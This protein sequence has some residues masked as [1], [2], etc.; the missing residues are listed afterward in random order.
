VDGAVFDL[1]EDVAKELLSKPTRPGDVLD[2]PHKLP[3]LQMDELR[4]RSDMYG[5]FSQD[6][7][8]QRSFDSR[9][10]QGGNRGDRF[11]DRDRSNRFSS[12]GSDRGGG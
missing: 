10:S 2:V 6:G 1:P 8:R 7:G 3:R 5:R 11:G 9:G 12:G 4:S